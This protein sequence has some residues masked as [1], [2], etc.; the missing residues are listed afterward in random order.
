MAKQGKKI[1]GNVFN[2]MLT[3][4]SKTEGAAP[5]GKSFMDLFGTY[6]DAPG[7]G[8]PLKKNQKAP[9]KEWVEKHRKMQPRDPDGRFGYNSN[10]GRPLAAKGSRGKTVPHT[11]RSLQLDLIFEKYAPGAKIALDG[12]IGYIR[13]ITLTKEQFINAVREAN[14]HYSSA[15]Q[16]VKKNIDFGETEVEMK[17]GRTSKEEAQAKKATKTGSDKVKLLDTK[18]ETA[19]KE[20]E[21]KAAQERAQEYKY[22]PSEEDREVAKNDAKKFYKEHKGYVNRMA[23]MLTKKR[24]KKVSK[25][26]VIAAVAA[27]KLNS[28]KEAKNIKVQV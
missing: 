15:K 24:G 7:G 16:F 17:Q 10:N 11:I 18:E 22:V 9:S 14:E 26:A 20:T 21:K 12:K 3:E 1:I 5:K 2:K 23:E 13:S 8:T 4:G 28:I 25:S 19:R 6:Q 27:G